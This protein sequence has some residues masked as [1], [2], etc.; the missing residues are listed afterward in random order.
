[1]T[2]FL[3][4][5]GLRPQEFAKLRALPMFAGVGPADLEHLLDGS[6]VR[7]CA[8]G[9]ILFMQGDRA[10]RFYVVLEGW[11]RLVRHTPDGNEV[12]VAVFGEGESLA[13]AAVLE[14][15]TFPVEG[16]VV[17][18]SRLLGVPG[19]SFRARLRENPDL[20]FNIMATLSRRLLFFLQRIEQLSTHSTLERTALFLLRLAREE[21]G[22]AIVDLPLDKALIAA[23]LGMQPETLSR[24]FGKLRALGVKVE[25]ERVTMEEIE[26]LRQ[27][28]E[29]R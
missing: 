5:T 27:R 2:A 20:C 24:A 17:A 9:T 3:A 1:M 13:E 28:F 21:Q 11:V 23:R 26:R 10:D 18:P 19:T 12:T 8:R 14:L 6:M 25:G 22:R 15:A 29:G 7:T 4:H 16:Q